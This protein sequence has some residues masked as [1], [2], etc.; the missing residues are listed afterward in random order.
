MWKKSLSEKIAKVFEVVNY[1]FIVP[2]ILI[3]FILLLIFLCGL[4]S[5]Q[6]LSCIYALIFFFIIGI[7]VILFVGYIKHSRGTLDESKILPL[8]MVTFLYN[9]LPLM[10]IG[11]RFYGDYQ[12]KISLEDFNVFPLLLVFWWLAA[13]CLS[14]TA[15]YDEL[16]YGDGFY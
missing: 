9:V 8:W 13:V 4:F 16:K 14:L 15:I 1:I 2:A 7:G 10:F 6:W 3:L 11:F 12:N 5:L